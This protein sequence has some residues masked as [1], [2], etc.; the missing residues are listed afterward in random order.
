MGSIVDWWPARAQPRGV[1][2]AH[3]VGDRTSEG[4][5]RG[6]LFAGS[7]TQNQQRR[8]QMSSR[9]DAKAE[10]STRAAGRGSEIFSSLL[11]LSFNQPFL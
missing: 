8:D 5:V 7:D 2:V 9:H 3:V 1:G 10:H 6:R 4:R 11:S